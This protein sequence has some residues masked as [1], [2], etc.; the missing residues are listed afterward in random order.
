MSLP[1]EIL[2]GTTYLITRRCTQR[3][4]LLSPSEEVNQIFLYCLAIAAERTSVRV[5]AF[6]VMSNHW[7]A[8]VTDVEGKLPEFM[9][10]VH[11][12]VAKCMNAKLGRW[13]NFWSST[14]YSA[15]RLESPDDVLDKIVYVLTNAVA[16]GL[17][18]RSFRW[19]G[20]H[21][22]ATDIGGKP[23]KVNRPKVHFLPEGPMPDRASLALKPPPPFVSMTRRKF[24][25]MIQGRVQ[26]MENMIQADFRK[27]GRR[28]LGPKAC[29]KQRH[30]DHPA[31]Q[32]P[33]REISPK[34][35]ARDKALRTAA[36]QRLRDFVT[37]YRTAFLKWKK[38]VRNV[39]FP[40][41]T[42]WLRVH[43]AARCRSPA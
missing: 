17:V 7:H 25:A 39:L 30:T 5:H 31:T 36:L 21:S 29:L 35:A 9:A 10:W 11:K 38:G 3:Q 14:P 33:R 27:K 24:V 32:E 20:L 26:E 8:V 34:I 4:F 42:Y 40:A 12:Y 2:P 41:G 19:P 6:C 13:E 15:V 28:F 37:A 43:A 22:V 16:A 23:M 1:R 18:A